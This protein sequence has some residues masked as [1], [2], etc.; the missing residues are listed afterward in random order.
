MT[1]IGHNTSY[2]QILPYGA[3]TSVGALFLGEEKH[4]KI[5]V[6]VAG[7]DYV[8]GSDCL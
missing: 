2:I 8:L 4:E 6:L 7:T 5:F 1:K 3:A